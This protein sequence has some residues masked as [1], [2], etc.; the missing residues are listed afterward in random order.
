MLLKEDQYN[1]CISYETEPELYITD[2]LS[3]QDHGE[4]RDEEVAGLQFTI[5]ATDAT[6]D[7]TTYMTKKT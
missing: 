1:I 7:I 3:T 2:W 5:K 6:T 4:N